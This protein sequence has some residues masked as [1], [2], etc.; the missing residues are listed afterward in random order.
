VSDLV[1]RLRARLDRARRAYAA[2]RPEVARFLF[3]HGFLATE[4]ALASAG[5]DDEPLLEALFTLQLESIGSRGFGVSQPHF[6][7]DPAY[8]DRYFALL[9][10][11]LVPRLLPLLPG[12]RRLP[13]V[14]ALFNLGEHLAV[15]SPGLGGA[16]VGHLVE[17]QARIVEEGVEAVGLSALVAVG[18]L[19]AEALRTVAAPTRLPFARLVTR[20]VASVA[21]WEPDLVPGALAFDAGALRVWDRVEARA[22]RLSF[23]GGSAQLLGREVGPGPAPTGAPLNTLALSVDARGTVTHE[24]RALGAIDPRGLLSLASDGVRVAVT[25]RFSQRVELYELSP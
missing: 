24:G 23:A 10:L 13:T 19:P 14:V 21:T 3:E 12:P 1:E 22:L 5:I 8:P 4:R 25:R 11:D 9:W 2:Y 17:H 18:V 6:R 16:V 15:A 7:D 20:A